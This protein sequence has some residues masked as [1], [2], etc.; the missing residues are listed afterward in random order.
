MSFVAAGRTELLILGR[1]I[2]GDVH[3]RITAVTL[4]DVLESLGF[5]V[6]WV[7]ME[8]VDCQSL[9]Q[10]SGCYVDISVGDLEH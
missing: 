9:Y 2:L 4:C 8:V 10:S 3:I 1:T 5:S 7:D 6:T